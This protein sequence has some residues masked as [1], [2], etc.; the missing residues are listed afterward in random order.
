MKIL[1]I[2]F[3]DYI[4][5]A[6]RAALRIHNCLLKNGID[7]N[8]L[9]IKKS[10]KNNIKVKEIYQNQILYLIKIFTYKI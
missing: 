3:S 8:L 1:H 10:K 5:G 7:S 2:S 4:G 6:S 9:V